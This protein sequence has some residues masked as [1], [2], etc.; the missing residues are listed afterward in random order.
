[1]G[2]VHHFDAPVAQSVRMAE[3]VR[4]RERVREVPHN[5]NADGF[6][7]LAPKYAGGRPPKFTLPDRQAVKK[8]ALGRPGDYGELAYTPH[9][10]SWLNRI[11]AQ[12]TA[13]RYFCLD[14]TDHESHE[15]QAFLIRRYIAWRNR[16]ARDDAI[17]ELVKRAN[18]A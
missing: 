7:S 16:N 3:R 1:V 13:L 9:Y 12:F 4:V 10:A 5:F 15:A 17:R 14:G 11:E 18:V 6:D 8:I 2:R